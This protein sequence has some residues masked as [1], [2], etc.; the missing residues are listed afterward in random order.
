MVIVTTPSVPKLMLFVL[1]A[2]RHPLRSG[3]CTGPR[4]ATHL[5]SISQ[6]CGH[7][8]AHA[9]SHP[10]TTQDAPTAMLLDTRC[11]HPHNILHNILHRMRTAPQ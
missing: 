9:H 3:S 4:I 5:R 6:V 2:A 11:V 7:P 1:A 8:A 10:T